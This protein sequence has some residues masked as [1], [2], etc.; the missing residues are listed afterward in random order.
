MSEKF[1]Q[2]KI[3]V[4]ND[5]AG[6]G[7]C[8]LTI[9]IPV[10]SSMRVACCPVPTSIFSNH[11]G[12]PYFHFRDLTGDMVPYMENWKK[13]NVSFDGII[14]G[15]LGSEKQIDIVGEFI[16]EFKTKSTYVIIDPIMGDHGKTYSAYT[17]DM[18]SKMKE[19]VQYADIL[20]PNVTEACILTDTPYK[21][22]WQRKEIVKIAEKL[23]SMGP[24]KVVITGIVQKT[25]I[26]N[27][28]FEKNEEPVFI[29]THKIGTGRH[30]TGDIFSSMIAADA[31]NGTDFRLS[32]KKAALFIKK[33]IQHSI[34]LDIPEPEGVA[35]EDLL[36]LLNKS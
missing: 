28:C 21:D 12:F 17:L 36:Y 23:C 25:Y 10:I 32:V 2:K 7:K 29:S 5:L 13:L 19:L 22:S 18:C 34:D 31:V 30:G 1:T 8:A 27:L 6:Y 11:T 24:S 4:I 33:C 15:Y 20:T 16:K 35:F 14:S 3:A 26:T 9:S